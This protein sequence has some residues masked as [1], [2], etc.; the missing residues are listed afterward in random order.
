MLLALLLPA[1]AAAQTARVTGVVADVTGAVLPGV[2]VTLRA[3]P[4]GAVQTT[5]TDSSGRYAFDNVAPGPY[6]IS[7]DLPGFVRQLDRITVPA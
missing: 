1:A 6:E 5:V 4:A 2:T 3:E 7:Y